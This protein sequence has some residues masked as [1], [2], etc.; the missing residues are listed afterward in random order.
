MLNI[1]TDEFKSVVLESKVPVMVDFWADWCGPCKMLAPTLQK[2]SDELEGQAT[3]CKVNVDEERAIA[4]Q[5]EIS[6]IPTLLVFKEGQLVERRS[7]VMN[8]N[9]LKQLLNLNA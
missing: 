3:I 8:I 2:L 4:A 1:T 6:S 7:G 5:Y 9:Q